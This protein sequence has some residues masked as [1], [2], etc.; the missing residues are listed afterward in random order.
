MTRPTSFLFCALL[1]SLACE[2][3][4][5]MPT[6][7]AV[8]TRALGETCGDP[9]ECISGFCV[10]VSDIRGVC[11]R[12]C[13]S[14]RECPPGD[15]WDCAESVDPA[16]PRLCGCEADA[17]GEI[18]GDGRDNDCNGRSDDCLVCGGAL[19]AGDDD[20][21][22][23][24]CFEACRPDE[25]CF[26]GDCRC[27]DPGETSCGGRCVDIAS[28]ARHCGACGNACRIGDECVDGTCSCPGA[29]PDRCGEGC[30]DTSSDPAHCGGCGRACDPGL[31]CIDGAC[32]CPGQRPDLCADECVDRATDARH[33]GACGNAC[34]A[35]TVCR[36][37]ACECGA[38][39]VA[40]RCEGL[41]CV[42]LQRDAAHC[43]GCGDA[44]EA[45]LVCRD[46]ACACP[47]SATPDHCPG[48]GCVSLRTR[49]DH[50]G[51]CGSA[52]PAGL[53]CVDGACVCP[54]GGE[55]VCGGE[56]VDTRWD[57]RHCGGCGTACAP[58]ERCSGGACM[59]PSGLHCGGACVTEGP[60][61]C[62]GC[63]LRCGP[64]EVCGG[65]A[66][67]CPSASQTSCGDGCFDLQ[68]DA[69]HCGDCDTSCGAG[70]SCVGGACVCPSGLTWCDVAGACVDL[71]GDGD[72][73][74]AC[75]QTCGGAS[76]CMSGTCRCSTWGATF[77]SSVSECVDTQTDP[78]H[79]GACDAACP[80]NTSCRAR[81]CECDDPSL[82]LCA[83]ACIDTETDPASC[84]RCGY[85]CV[86]G[87]VCREG[88]CSCEAFAPG[89][90]H[91][92]TTTIDET[93]IQSAVAG[94]GGV[95]VLYRDVAS[96]ARTLRFRRLDALGT[97]VGAEVDL[98]VD[99]TGRL[100]WTGTAWVVV[101]ADYDGGHR[102]VLRRLDASGVAI[103]ADTAIPATD[104]TGA[105]L[106][107][108]PLLELTHS[109]TLGAVVAIRHRREVL[110]QALGDGSTPANPI[111]VGE[112][113]DCDVAA[114]PSGAIGVLW[115]DASYA[116]ASLL[117]QQIEPDG[118][119]ISPQITVDSR[120]DGHLDLAHD[121]SDFAA[122]YV[123]ARVSGFTRVGQGVRVA[124]GPGLSRRRDV[125]QHDDPSLFL[126]A[127]PRIAS[128]SGVNVV[129]WNHGSSRELVGRLMAVRFTSTL[130]PLGPLEPLVTTPTVY[131]WL[132]SPLVLTAP[133]RAVHLWHD[134][135]YAQREVF[136]MSTHIPPCP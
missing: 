57:A 11:S 118:S 49:A 133:D 16:R 3:P 5:P 119:V 76:F 106:T 111:L 92:L 23:G 74:G 31:S 17:D 39:T 86:T 12:P 9:S 130:T 22:C 104:E 84:G 52:C 103:G 61:H 70:Q 35:G 30:Y 37:G 60:T 62:G 128:A 77:C 113:T 95:G 131:R 96:S 10:A 18:C 122:T 48:A 112:S 38:S 19:I 45:G 88:A 114:A 56:C 29:R 132:A 54:G 121:G 127:R 100:A 42:D 63:D 87:R 47:S 67:V 25:V 78:A 107:S 80:A 41:G 2:G 66:C 75:G 115:D 53:G 15:N 1:V 116:S 44:C 68:T 81:R 71:T 101:W 98:G 91:R 120:H 59:C 27:R 21:H 102:L 7:G 65:G 43:G 28:D 117:F 8:P 20:A 83:G 73:C 6:D 126:Y 33:C 109:S 51:A 4:R 123:A 46:G 64:G 136:A 90:Q 97:P 124:N 26:S 55:V 85:A 105:P 110:V 94:A 69:L 72:H 24:A 93:D 82:T 36:D 79:C 129:S 34:P 32:A 89:T 50:C 13:T 108:A 40:D 14:A 58:G 134:T 99:A 135:R 125:A